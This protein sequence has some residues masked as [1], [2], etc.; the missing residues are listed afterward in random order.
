MSNVLLEFFREFVLC[1]VLS[2]YVKVS[3]INQDSFDRLSSSFR[4]K[5]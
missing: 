1:Q 2:K 5:I 4:E 3:I